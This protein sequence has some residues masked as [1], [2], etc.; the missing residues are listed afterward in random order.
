MHD[1]DIHQS[2]YIVGVIPR[3]QG[4]DATTYPLPIISGEL[5]ENL[6]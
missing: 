6:Q 1:H 2:G 3:D 5:V 4:S